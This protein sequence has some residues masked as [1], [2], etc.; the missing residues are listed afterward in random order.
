MLFLRLSYQS[1]VVVLLLRSFYWNSSPK[2]GQ[3]MSY[4]IIIDEI[5]LYI[6]FSFEYIES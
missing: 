6:L 4:T 1:K 5:V 2:W 3:S